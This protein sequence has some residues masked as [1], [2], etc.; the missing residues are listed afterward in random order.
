MRIGELAKKTGLSVDAI[1]FYEKNDLISKPVRSESGYREF[2]SETGDTL[3][4]IAHCRSLD[5]P[6]PQIK[7]LLRVR[8]GSAK[9]CREAN[10]VIDEQVTNL[11][12]R[13]SKLKT[14][15]KALSELRKVCERELDPMDCKIIK[16]LQKPRR[17]S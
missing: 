8:S 10:E 2:S 13:I 4:F 16:S 1:R 9:S 5:I 6:L 14:L 17:S 15:E 12:E 7:K 3:E 11:R